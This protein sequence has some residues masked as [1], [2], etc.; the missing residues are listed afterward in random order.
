MQPVHTLLDFVFMDAKYLLKNLMFCSWQTNMQVNVISLLEQSGGQKWIFN[1]D[2]F[3]ICWFAD[4]I[5]MAQK[6]IHPLKQQ[7]KMTLPSINKMDTSS[8]RST[9]P[10]ILLT[11]AVLC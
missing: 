1:T 2:L 8:C 6:P 10:S 7:F 9:F 3:G 4:W 11:E 5:N